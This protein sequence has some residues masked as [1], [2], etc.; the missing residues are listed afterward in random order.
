MV[1]EAHGM[2]FTFIFQGKDSFP[3]YGTFNFFQIKQTNKQKSSLNL[4]T[5]VYKGLL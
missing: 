5:E 4:W 2:S 3:F 1:F